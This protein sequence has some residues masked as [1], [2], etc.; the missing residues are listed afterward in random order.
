MGH[1]RK[2]KDTNVLTY[3]RRFPKDL[4]SYIPS[5]SPE[6]RGRAE[7][8]VSLRTTDMDT[9]GAKDRLAE[10]ERDY[11]AL[12]EKARRVATGNFDR[13]DPHLI[14]YLADNY[15]HEQLTLDE[16]GRWGR[17]GPDVAYPSRT[18][19]ED[20]YIESRKL[21]DAYDGEGLVA[22]WQDWARSYA[23]DAGFHLN[24]VDPDMPKNGVGC[25]PIA[26]W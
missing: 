23:D 12:V 2:D 15:L 20:D 13:L 17:A 21:L 25:M 24:P 7:F 6:G 14:R 16:A 11:L 18:N 19:R 1:I 26:Q 4:V 3:R 22:H 10:A 8:K 5:R 9:A